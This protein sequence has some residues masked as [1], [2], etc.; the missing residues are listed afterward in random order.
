MTEIRTRF[1]SAN[2][3]RFEIDEAGS[4]SDVVLFLHGFPESRTSWR[5]QLPAL[6]TDG[7]LAA[8]PD[9]RGYG[10][11]SRPAGRASYHIDALCADVDALFEALGARRRVLVGHDWG[12]VIAWAYAIRAGRRLDD[13]VIL[14]APHP[15]AYFEHLRTHPTQMLKS[16]YV[17]FFQIPWLPEALSR[18][19]DARAI[20]RAF[21]T[22]AA[23]GT[24]DAERLS[25][26][27]AR[28][29]EPGAL[30]AMINYYRANT[31]ALGEISAG[32][33]TRVEARTL[34][35]WGARDAFLDADLA[36]ASAAYAPGAEVRRLAECGH[37]LQQEAPERVNAAIRTWLGAPGPH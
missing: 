26:Y 8:A 16:W 13:L 21:E 24:F 12:G 4:G 15:S 25:H 36:E 30:T 28:A 27:V 17:L 7:W 33:D 22:N 18:A 31:R 6:A 37:W 1:I 5:A 34:V 14:N 11:S 20:R 2:G 23:P 9:L 35:L 3:L 10:R 29:R 32:A 19:A